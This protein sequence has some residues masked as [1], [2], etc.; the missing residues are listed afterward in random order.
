MD[1]VTGESGI[2]IS[3][4]DI[5]EV[6]EV[7][8]KCWDEYYD[9]EPGYC[10]S[11]LR[12]L[13]PGN[14]VSSSKSLLDKLG[15]AAWDCGL[16]EWDTEESAAS[17]PFAT[18][19]IKIQN[20]ITSEVTE[21]QIPCYKISVSNFPPV[22]VYEFCTRLT[23]CL[24]SSL[25]NEE[26]R[27]TGNYDEATGQPKMGYTLWIY[28]CPFVDIDESFPE[29]SRQSFLEASVLSWEDMRNVDNDVQVIMM[30]TVLRLHERQFPIELLDE[31]FILPE[32]I[33]PSDN[34]IVTCLLQ[35][36]KYRS[37]NRPP[38]WK[39]GPNIVL[40]IDREENLDDMLKSWCP[41]CM[42]HECTPHLSGSVSFKNASQVTPLPKSVHMPTEECDE[43]CILL[44]PNG[45]GFIWDPEDFDILRKYLVTGTLL[46]WT[47]PCE[48]AAI[49]GKPCWETYAQMTT[50]LQEATL[51]AGNDDSS[52]PTVDKRRRKALQTAKPN[53]EDYMPFV[54]SSGYDLS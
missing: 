5:A 42:Q 10:T 46:E 22:P 16:Q 30:E 9:W 13:E 40:P 28:F 35:T 47:I 21:H 11:K 33:F 14:E 17:E 50:I 4:A 20:E 36:W 34:D 39:N 3:K 45:E 18:K 49:L 24:S 43:D 7:Y 25:D 29:A 52:S 6:R 51:D 32:S 31:I 37:S 41:I 54:S 44:N 27:H 48:I 12:S 8:Q 23:K 15:W 26:Y 19:T 1:E 53:K 2:T 38:H